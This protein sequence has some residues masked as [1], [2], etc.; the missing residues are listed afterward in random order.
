MMLE[1]IIFNYKKIIKNNLSTILKLII[2][3]SLQINISFV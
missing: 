2:I 1:I 3:I